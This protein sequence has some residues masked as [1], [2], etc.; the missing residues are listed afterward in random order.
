MSTS[1]VST[2]PV[3]DDTNQF[4][5]LSTTESRGGPSDDKVGIEENTS[6]VLE[7]IKVH[8]EELVHQLVE[9][10]KNGTSQSDKNSLE[11]AVDPIKNQM[12]DVKLEAHEQLLVWV[13]L[14]VILVLLTGDYIIFI[15]L[16][17]FTLM[18]GHVYG[19]KLYCTPGAPKLK[20]VYYLS[21][22]LYLLSGTGRR[23]TGLS[24]F[25]PLPVLFTVWINIL[26]ILFYK[27]RKFSVS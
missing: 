3:V 4:L 22:G 21:I 27:A 1:S 23:A 20:R 10:N 15:K 5:N 19:P 24:K 11:I 14:A 26:E 7:S 8:L 2:M 9:D 18:S 6:V 13:M 16:E 17:G 12:E 25:P